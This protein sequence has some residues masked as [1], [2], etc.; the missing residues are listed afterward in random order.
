M[1]INYCLKNKLTANDP[2]VTFETPKV[3]YG[4][5]FYLNL[6]EQILPK[7]NVTDYNKNISKILRYVGIDVD[8]KCFTTEWIEEKSKIFKYPDK[9]LIEK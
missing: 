7:F 1:V 8:P 6:E 2:F 3:I 9:N 5:P 4:S